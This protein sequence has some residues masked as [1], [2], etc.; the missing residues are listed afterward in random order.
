MHNDPEILPPSYLL[1]IVEDIMGKKATRWTVPDCGLSSA[2][3]FSVQL[4]DNSKVFVKA[5][6]DEDTE[7]WLRTEHLVLSSAQKEFMPSVLDWIDEPGI[8]PVLISQDLSHAYWPASHSGVV[9]RDGDIDL[10]LGGI[11]ELSLQTAPPGLP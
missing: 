10:L 5:A 7:Q 4:E 8:H 1:D 11:R 2:L 6:T 3:R 9:W